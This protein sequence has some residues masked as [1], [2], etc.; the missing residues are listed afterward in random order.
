[1]ISVNE[2]L[3]FVYLF[4]STWLLHEFFHIKSHGIRRTGDIYVNEFGLTASPYEAVR[5]MLWFK[6]AGGLLASVVSFVVLL[7]SSPS[8]F[9]FGLLVMGW[10]QLVYGVYEGF[11][12]ENRELVRHGIYLVVFVFWLTVWVVL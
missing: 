2:L 7:L 8:V 1:M 6:L 9:S 12:R 10:M 3:V 5:S 11:A 4:V